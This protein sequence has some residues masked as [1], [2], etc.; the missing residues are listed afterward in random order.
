MP[1]RADPFRNFVVADRLP[2][3]QISLLIFNN[4][5][6][7]TDS[8]GFDEA[9]CS[10]IRSQE[11]FNFA[12]QKLIAFAGRIQKLSNLVRLLI[13]RRAKDFLDPS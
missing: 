11:R 3:E 10:L 12:T 1:P 8:C 6:R 4:P 9:A 5:R 2:D 7:K 13:Q